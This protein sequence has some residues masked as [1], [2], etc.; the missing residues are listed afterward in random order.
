MYLS[1]GEGGT[2][3]LAPIAPGLVVA[4]AVR[5]CRILPLE[6]PVALD[7]D[8][9]VLALDGERE[10]ELYGARDVAVRMGKR[11]PLVVDIERCME[12]AARLG[13]FRE[14]CDR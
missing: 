14:L 11:G 7:P 13:V 6:E 10:I 2:R 9:S 8:V 12:T 5:E 4:V 1:L 3:V